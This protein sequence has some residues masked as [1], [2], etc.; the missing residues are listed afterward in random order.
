AT[1]VPSDLRSRLDKSGLGGHIDER[2]VSVVAVERILSVVS[3]EQVIESVVVVLE[4]AAVRLLAFGK[5]FQS[6]SIDE[7]EIDPTVMVIV[8]EG[9]TATS[10]LKQVL[11]L[12]LASVDSRPSQAGLG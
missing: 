8:V 5:A 10:G 3:H 6:P 2:A 9:Q 7:K 11:I 12:E 1:G 4:K